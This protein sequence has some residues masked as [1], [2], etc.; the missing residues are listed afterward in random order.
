LTVGVAK[1]GAKDCEGDGV[2][3]ESTK[4]DG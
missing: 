4:G 3:K 2:V 1:G